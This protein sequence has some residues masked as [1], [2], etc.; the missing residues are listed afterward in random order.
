MSIKL[1]FEVSAPPFRWDEA[2]GIRIGESRV[3]LDS[4]LSAYH[5]GS[6]PE[7]I[8]VQYSVLH[9][10]EIYASVAYYLSHRQ[11]IDSY[12]QQRQRKSQQQR[13][14]FAQQYNLAN[15]RQRLLDRSSLKE[16]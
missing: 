8:A 12:L 16:N 9:L 4:L 3:T 7:E 10:E 14:E 1:E 13:S 2:G 6:T 11:Q 15:L 5:S